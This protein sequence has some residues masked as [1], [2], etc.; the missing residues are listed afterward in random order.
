L[1]PW[2]ADHVRDLVQRVAH[3]LGGGAPEDV[4]DEFPTAEQQAL[5]AA[6]EQVVRAEGDHLMVVSPDRQ[7]LFSRVAGVL[8]L[9]GLDV[10]D[11][12]ATTR[13]GVA[14]EVF[15]V[16]S[17][18]GPAFS[19]SRVLLDLDRALAGRLA[20][21]ARIAERAR[22]YARH[23]VHE[24]V[25]PSVVFHLDA[26]DDAT[27]VEVH[28]PNAIGVLYRI[29]RSLA[30]LD[31]DIV[32]AKVQTLGNTVVDSFYV[33]DGEGNRVTDSTVLVEI[34]RALLHGL[35]TA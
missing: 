35:T 30:E 26:S 16:E 24:P 20:L 34:E 21:H 12:A 19:W 18:F 33:R 1:G 25:E 5:L 13:D 2:K 17:S 29:T 11:A 9:H 15:R 8:A 31:L 6:G 3:V 32:S 7:G 14:L 27:V 22:V 23:D 28:A 10:L 4:A